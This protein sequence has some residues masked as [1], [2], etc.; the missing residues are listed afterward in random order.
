MMA[1]LASLVWVRRNLCIYVYTKIESEF[2][3]NGLPPQS[4]GCPLY[5][6]TVSLP[7]NA[8]QLFTIVQRRSTVLPDRTLKQ[9]RG[10]GEYSQ[11]FNKFY[12][13]AVRICLSALVRIIKPCSVGVSSDFWLGFALR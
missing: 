13:P 8:P 1:M 10:R 3:N 9:N 12:S 4:G 11:S 5:L 7:V 2:A 6:C